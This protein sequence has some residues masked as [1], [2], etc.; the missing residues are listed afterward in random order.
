MAFGFWFLY[1][2]KMNHVKNGLCRE[3]ITWVNGNVKQDQQ[4]TN[5]VTVQISP[6]KKDGTT[7]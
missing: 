7:G 6:K 3:I 5:D 1:R 4:K 2:K